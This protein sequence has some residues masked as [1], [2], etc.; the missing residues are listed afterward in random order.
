MDF[1]ETDGDNAILA[2]LNALRLDR[3]G[4]P[5][6]KV[7]INTRIQYLE[8]QENWNWPPYMIV[9]LA[10]CDGIFE[11]RVVHK[12]VQYRPLGCYG[13]GEREFTLLIGACEE[14]DDFRPREAPRIAE[15]RRATILRDPGR[16]CR[17][18]YS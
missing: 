12:N 6:A 15:D 11:L 4:E 9:H 8:A 14:N 3:G 1:L 17:H 5:R 18:D 2:W 7:K 13:P 16:V 10:D